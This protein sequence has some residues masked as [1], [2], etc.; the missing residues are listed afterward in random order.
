MGGELLF[1]VICPELLPSASDVTQTLGLYSEG[2][3]CQLVIIN[4]LQERPLQGFDG[5]EFSF[6]CLF[7]ESLS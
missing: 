7:L 5:T 4:S 6:V 1:S 3:S 2:F